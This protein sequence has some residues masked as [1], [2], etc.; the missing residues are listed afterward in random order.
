MSSVTPA[1]DGRAVR[2]LAVSGKMASG[3]DAVAAE[4]LRRLGLEP[5]RVNLADAIRAEVQHCYDLGGYD[6]VVHHLRRRDPAG[7][8][9]D[10]IDTVAHITGAG[11]DAQARTAANRVALQQLAHLYRL[12]DPTIWVRRHREAVEAAG[13]TVV[14]TTDVRQPDEV[15]AVHDAG[16]I[17]VRLHVTADTQ[18]QRLMTRDGL[19]VDETVNHPN[20]TALDAPHP[21]V[22]ARI[23]AHISN[24]GT[25]DA[26][27]DLLVELLA[28]RWAL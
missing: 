16:F 10:L 26:A 19:V 21:S 3:K 22:L 28:D 6:A 12:D 4:A 8:H 24:D 20:E 14:S 7:T 23:D 2:R 17:V 15:V 9:R 11:G 25:L 13:T 18:R 5:R 1:N 27:A